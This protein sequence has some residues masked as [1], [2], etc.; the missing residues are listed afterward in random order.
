MRLT[1]SFSPRTRTD[2]HRGS[3]AV[4]GRCRRSQ[5]WACA[6]LRIV[7]GCC[8]KNTAVC[9]HARHY[10]SLMGFF[11]SKWVLYSLLSRVN[12]INRR[13]QSDK[14]TYLPSRWSITL[15]SQKVVSIYLDCTENQVFMWKG[16][17]SFMIIFWPCM[18]AE[19]RAT[20]TYCPF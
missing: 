6:S 7:L 20:W 9:E 15:D 10:C 2:A 1:S 3:C 17:Y 19:Q 5:S 18:V 4:V 13:S 16:L 11:S 12:F 8:A 14:L